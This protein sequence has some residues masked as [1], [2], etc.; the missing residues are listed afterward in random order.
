MNHSQFQNVPYD[1]LLVPVSRHYVCEDTAHNGA[2]GF[3]RQL[4]GLGSPLLVVVMVTRASC[5][6]HSS[7]LL[8]QCD[9]N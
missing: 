6:S 3:D 8:T 5:G 9:G 2:L 4:L 7:S 1:D